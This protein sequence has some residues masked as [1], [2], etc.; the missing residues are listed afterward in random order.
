MQAT[1]QH[2]YI[3]FC[4]IFPQ[5]GLARPDWF[6][7]YALAQWLQATKHARSSARFLLPPFPSP[8]FSVSSSVS[9]TFSFIGA[10]DQHWDAREHRVVV[11]DSRCRVGLTLEAC[12]IMPLSSLAQTLVTLIDCALMMAFY[13]FWP[14]FVVDGSRRRWI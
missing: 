4:T 3:V 11:V 6:S 7:S 1:K 10:I 9:L 14:L 12:H 5:P 8:R 2:D 13:F